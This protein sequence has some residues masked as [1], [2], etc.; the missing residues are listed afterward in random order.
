MATSKKGGYIILDFKDYVLTRDT[1]NSVIIKGLYQKLVNSKGK[2]IRIINATESESIL[3]K[4]DVYNVT[5][6]Y[7]NESEKSFFLWLSIE[8]V[9]YYIL[10]KEN[11]S[12][13]F[14]EY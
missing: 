9:S 2:D 4:E 8:D 6:V 12:V 11:D 14:V 13:V 10:V 3:N 1:D 5:H 7:D